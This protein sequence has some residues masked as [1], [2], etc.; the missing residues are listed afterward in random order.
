MGVPRERAKGREAWRDIAGKGSSKCQAGIEAEAG[1]EV[2]RRQGLVWQAAE[3][4]FL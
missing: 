3:V 1:N 4:G 2:E